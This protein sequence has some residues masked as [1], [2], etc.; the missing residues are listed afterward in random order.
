MHVSVLVWSAVAAVAALVLAVWAD[1]DSKRRRDAVLSHAPQPIPGAP[2]TPEPTYVL[3]DDL[4]SAAG[5]RTKDD[6]ATPVAVPDRP[7]DLDHGWADKG[8]VTA[9][10]D[11]LAVV[12]EALVL[13]ADSIGSFRELLTPLE[14]VRAAGAGFV[15]VAGDI[16][17]EPLTT[18]AANA[19]AGNLD[20]VAIREPDPDARARIAEQTGG[21]ATRRAD[22]QAG[23]VPDGVLGS[24][25][26][27]ISTCDASWA[28][29]A[30]PRPEALAP[31]TTGEP[32]EA[33]PTPRAPGHEASGP[34]FDPPGRGSGDTPHATVSGGAAAEP[35][36]GR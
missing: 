6:P 24:C 18:L 32:A 35:D 26:G 2:E 7:P 19:R 11:G 25:R 16:G 20:C 21:L 14:R 27:W 12:G 31:L 15:L 34:G 36:D 28:E 13:V 30:A 3:P 8:F 5:G 1:S 10:R 23:Y 17:G 33:L 22:L 4:A 9:H 29:T